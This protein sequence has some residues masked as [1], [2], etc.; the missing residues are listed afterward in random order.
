MKKSSK[1]RLIIAYQLLTEI[2][3]SFENK[4]QL[5]TGGN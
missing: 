2:I 1:R 5:I 4:N 3:N